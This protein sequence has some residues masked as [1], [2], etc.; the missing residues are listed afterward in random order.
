MASRASPPRGLCCARKA[1]HVLD[2]SRCALDRSA[3]GASPLIMVALAL[4]VLRESP[5]HMLL[6]VP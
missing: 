5:H 2:S 4:H 3:M 6:E 1:R